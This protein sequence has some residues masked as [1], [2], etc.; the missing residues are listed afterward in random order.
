[1]TT[2]EQNEVSSVPAS[3]R[4]LSLFVL[5]AGVTMLIAFVALPLITLVIGR[6]TGLEFVENLERSVSAMSFDAF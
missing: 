1:M 2:I 3:H 6:F 4:W 5:F